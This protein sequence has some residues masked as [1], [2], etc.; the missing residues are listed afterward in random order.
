MISKWQE[1]K[2]MLDDMEPSNNCYSRVQNLI[3]E[4]DKLKK[5][6]DAYDRLM[7]DQEEVKE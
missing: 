5:K 6:A 3:R 4:G 1:A 7:G 2:L